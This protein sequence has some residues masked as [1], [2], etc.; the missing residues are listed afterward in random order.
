MAQNQKPKIMMITLPYSTDHNAPAAEDNSDQ[1]QSSFAAHF[2]ENYSK[3]NQKV[4]DP[5][6]GFGT[7]AF[8]AEELNRTPYGIEADRTRFE[9]AAGQLEHWHNIKHGDARDMVDFAL[10]KMDLC[11]T[12]PPFMPITDKWNPLYG[13]DHVHAGYDNYLKRLGEIFALTAAQMKRGAH[14]I[15]HC[16]N[17]QTRRF[18]PLMRDISTEVSKHLRP[19]NEIIVQWDGDAPQT[20]TH[21]LIFKKI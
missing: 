21:A 20:H 12:S 1:F 6:L 15:V 7:T 8:A 18:T 10:P 11:V 14:V 5:F 19:E 2:I 3:P 13:G 17:I 9:W 4:F 16:D